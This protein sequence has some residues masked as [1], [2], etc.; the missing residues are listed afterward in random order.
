MNGRVRRCDKVSWGTTEHTGLGV[1]GMTCWH[2]GST[3]DCIV[4]NDCCVS[5]RALPRRRGLPKDHGERSANAGNLLDRQF[6]AD[7]PNRK[8]VADFIYIWTAA[9]WLYVAV[10]LDLYSRRIVGWSMQSS[11]TS[12]LVADA[13]MR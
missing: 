8:W 5:L 10:V 1:S 2:W 9:G 4:S 6:K 13:L 3:A 12:Q 7:A 11:M